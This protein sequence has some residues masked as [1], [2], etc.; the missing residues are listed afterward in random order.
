M[1][2][3]FK[4]PS[5]IFYEIIVKS[6]P[7]PILLIVFFGYWKEIQLLVLQYMFFYSFILPQGT[8]QTLNLLVCLGI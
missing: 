4:N 5:L 2:S 1:G 6:L 3:E 7:A 8:T